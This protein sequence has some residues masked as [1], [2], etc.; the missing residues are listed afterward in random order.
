MHHGD[1]PSHLHIPRYYKLAGDATS[2]ILVYSLHGDR[3]LL[4]ASSSADSMYIM[5]AN[6]YVATALCR[7]PSTSADMNLTGSRALHGAEVIDRT[8]S[9][10]GACAT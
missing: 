1:S 10:R 2:A 7:F 6:T 8:G 4:F 9:R 3:A 5:M